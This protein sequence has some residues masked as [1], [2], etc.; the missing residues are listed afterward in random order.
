MT[1]ESKALVDGYVTRTFVQR[2]RQHGAAEDSVIYFK[3]VAQLQSV[4]ALEHFHVLL[5]GA[6]K[7]LLDEWT[8]GDVPMYKM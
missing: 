8:E 3:N 7:E 5:R 6:K 1:P 4:G 2:M